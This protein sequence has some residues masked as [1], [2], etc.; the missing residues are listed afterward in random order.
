[1]R[2]DGGPVGAARESGCGC[3]CRCRREKMRRW[4]W[5][6]VLAKK[7]RQRLDVLLCYYMR[8]EILR[9]GGWDGVYLIAVWGD[10]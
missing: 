7:R 1:M 9:K 10:V 4:R 6:A 8:M 2:S 3:G 5:R